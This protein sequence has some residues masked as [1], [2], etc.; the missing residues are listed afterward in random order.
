MMSLNSDRLIELAARAD[1]ALSYED[2][3]GHRQEMS[4]MRLQRA[5]DM[6]GIAADTDAEID[7]ALAEM[8]RAAASEI[9][10]NVMVV[11]ADDE[12]AITLNAPGGHQ[13]A[14]WQ[15]T[16]EDG[17]LRT[18]R[19]AL[20]D[21]SSGSV[22]HLRADNLPPGY[23]RLAIGFGGGDD[24]F[25]AESDF[26][27][28]PS[29]CYLPE[30]LQANQ[31]IWGLAAQL[32][33]LNAPRNWGLGDFGDLAALCATAG[34]MGAGL[35]GLSPL[36]AG[37]PAAPERFSPYAPVSRLTL[38]ALFIDI[39]GVPEFAQSES[40]K[41][42][43][44]DGEFQKQLKAARQAELIDYPL[45]S[46]LKYRMLR[47]L[48]ARFCDLHLTETGAVKS[49]RGERFA[50]FKL[51]GEGWLFHRAQFDALSDDFAAE[52]KQDWRAWPDAFHDPRSEA[53]A[54]FARDHRQQVDFYLYLQFVA[55]EQLKAARQHGQMNGLSLGLYLDLAVGT[56]A[57]SADVWADQN[58]H[59]IKASVGAPPDIFSPAGQSWGLAPLKPRSLKQTSYRSFTRLLRQNM[60]HAGAL[61]IDHALGLLQQYWVPLDGTAW[62]GAYIRYPTEDLLGLIALESQ[63]NQCVV[64][65][66]DLGTVPPSF[67][68]QLIARGILSYRI[69][70]FEQDENRAFVAPRHYP[71]QSL[72]AVTTHDLPTL[73]GFWTGHDLDV[74]TQLALF[75][76][77]HDI[78]AERADRALALGELEKA[79]RSAGAWTDKASPQPGPKLTAAAYETLGHAPSKIVMLTLEDALDMRDQPN[80]PGTIDEHPNWQHKLSVAVEDLASDP[81]LRTIVDA[82]AAARKKDA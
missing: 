72:A 82:L 64:I 24:E 5:L 69:L 45:V 38:N 76:K 23:H 17:T 1:I 11:R 37:Y 48:F 41:A 54:R 32:Y 3:W 73:R 34:D 14:H 8:D 39:E 36:H 57:E 31:K 47:Q 19:A 52:G 63:R 67:R 56:G 42:M 16:L 7:A 25:S 9:L 68:H 18:G 74:R 2:A 71:A 59:A 78:D 46:A 26:I 62:E 15:L 6:L 44:S 27:V 28:T 81:H 58:L 12:W 79:M 61:R 43:I 50:A 80:L 20:E 53:V 55:D 66:E 30:A 60:R 40:A 10:P 29:Q 21:G 65:G 75:P 4:P 70:Y 35:V 49:E 33:S 22:L 13:T 51:E 77:D